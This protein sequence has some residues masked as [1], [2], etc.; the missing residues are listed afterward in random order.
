MMVAPWVRDGSMYVHPSRPWSGHDGNAGPSQCLRANASP[1]RDL[2]ARLG[3]SST[4][5]R[6][7]RARFRGAKAGKMPR[8][9]QYACSSASPQIGGHDRCD[10]TV[11]EID[12]KIRPLRR[13][14]VLVMALTPS[15]TL[16]MVLAPTLQPTQQFLPLGRRGRPKDLAVANRRSGWAPARM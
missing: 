16:V 10:V 13:A 2:S 8:F 11:T 1:I 14:K 12:R 3:S 4:R 15:T 5:I 9:P 6:F 7:G